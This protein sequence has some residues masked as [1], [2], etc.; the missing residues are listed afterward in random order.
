MWHSYMCF[1]VHNFLLVTCKYN[2]KKQ[3]Q[4]IFIVIQDSKLTITI[5][6]AQQNEYNEM[7][8][9]IFSNTCNNIFLNF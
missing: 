2:K 7:Y 9:N 6:S 3:N 8:K 1:G 4:S 5:N